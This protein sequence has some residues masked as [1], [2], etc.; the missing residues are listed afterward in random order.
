MRKGNISTKIP[1]VWI[2]HGDVVIESKEEDTWFSRLGFNKRKVYGIS[3]ISHD[4]I[5]RLRCMGIKVEIKTEIKN[6]KLGDYID[7]VNCFYDIIEE[8]KMRWEVKRYIDNNYERLKVVDNLRLPYLGLM[9]F[10]TWNDFWK[11]I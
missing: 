7:E 10:T 11:N 4:Q 2:I 8:L 5:G 6:L 1:D 3:V 9:Q